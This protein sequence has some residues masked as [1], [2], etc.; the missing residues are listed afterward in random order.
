MAGSPIDP[1][2][3][4]NQ[5]S[6]QGIFFSNCFTPAYGTARGVWATITGIPDVAMVRT[7]TRIPRAVRQHTIVDDFDGYEKFYFIGGNATWANI[8]GLIKNN[9]RDLHLYEQGDYQSSGVDVWG[10]TDNDLFKEASKVINNQ[11]APFFSIIQT[12]SNHRPYTIPASDAEEMV[13]KKHPLDTLMKYG[14]NVEKNEAKTNEE[15]NSMR[16]MD[17]SIKNFM[18]DAKKQPWFSNTIF[19][20]VGDHGIRGNGRDLIPKVYTARGLTCQ[21]VPLLIYSPLLK[22]DYYDFPCS[23]V[24]VLPTLAGLA[25]IRYNNTTLG[26]DLL[27]IAKDTAA[28]KFAF[29][30]DHDLKQYGIMSD[31]QFYHKKINGGASAIEK[32][33]PNRPTNT[34]LSFYENLAEAIMYTSRYWMFNNK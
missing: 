14:F 32:I 3:Y 19:L 29:I 11:K 12:A 31:N 26:R 27:K 34:P 23:Q 1:T 6:K 15:Y 20:F 16:Y 5:L 8:R 21:H 18:E 33:D 2:P 24:D 28:P 4:F 7:S 30:L 22:S 10:I 13:I 25:N 17:F 9:I